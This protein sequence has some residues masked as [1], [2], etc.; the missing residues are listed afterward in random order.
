MNLHPEV[1]VEL[2]SHTDCKGSDAYNLRLSKRRAAVAGDYIKKQVSI[3]KN[4]VSIGYGEQKAR[5]V[6]DCEDLLNACNDDQNQL[7]RRTEFKISA[8]NFSTGK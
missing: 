6:C 1:T 7:N 4:V 3:R 2:G 8:L 5:V